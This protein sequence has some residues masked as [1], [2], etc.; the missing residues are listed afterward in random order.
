[1]QCRG[2]ATVA[3]P[4]SVPGPKPWPLVGNMFNADVGAIGKRGAMKPIYEEYG[5]IVKFSIPGNELVFLSDVTLAR[6]VLRDKAS[7]FT[8]GDQMRAVF[9]HL[10]PTSVIVVEGEQWKRIRR[11]ISRAIQGTRLEDALVPMRLVLDRAYAQLVHEGQALNM[12]ALTAGVTFDT[13]GFWGFGMDMNTIGG[14]NAHI[15]DDCNTVSAVLGKRNQ[16]PLPFLWKLPTKENR[17]VDAAVSAIRAFAEKLWDERLSADVDEERKDLLSAMVS[18][19]KEEGDQGLT[20]EEIIDNIATVFFGAYDT[21]SATLAFTLN[22]LA[23]HQDAQDALAAELATVN[24]QEISRKELEALPYL[25][26]VVRE[27][28]RLASTAMAFP[29]TARQDVEIGG[30]FIKQG[31]HLIVDHTNITSQ[32]PELWGGQQD[33]EQFRPSRWSEVKPHRLASLPFGFG[34]RMCPGNNV[35]TLEHKFI[36]ASLVSNYRW[37]V[38]GSRPMEYGVALGMA[39]KNGCWLIPAR[40]TQC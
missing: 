26:G 23:Q 2:C 35:A 19:S 34:G 1:M 28:N 32:D 15:L 31:T 17:G 21:T 14:E 7:S 39:P 3:L 29:R 33:L 27:A 24:L 9:G 4:L 12:H 37:T 5:P 38:D 30:Y 8:N 25:D 16:Q 40:R 18:A 13:F 11:V 20:R 36:T 22:F 6:E 10:F